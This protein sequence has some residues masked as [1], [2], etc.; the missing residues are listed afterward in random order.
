MQ[1]WP[2]LK[3]AADD[4][5][6]FDHGVA[7]LCSWTCWPLRPL[8]L[9]HTACAD[10]FLVLSASMLQ[11]CIRDCSKAQ[12]VYDYQGIP[13]SKPPSPNPRSGHAL[14]F[15]RPQSSARPSANAIALEITPDPSLKL[16][17]PNSLCI[18]QSHR[19]LSAL[20]EQGLTREILQFHSSA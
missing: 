2:S 5:N 11:K 10:E 6:S 14:L 4:F 12:P 20:W 18:L 9:F 16:F 3:A 8:S 13:F 19:R 1:H 15:F 7:L 17:F